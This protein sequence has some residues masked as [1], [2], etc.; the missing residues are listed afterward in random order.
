MNWLPHILEN[1]KE[2]FGDSVEIGEEFK[3]EW[4][5]IPHIYNVPFYVYAYSFGQLLVLSLYKQ[6]KAEGE[7]FKPRYIKILS[8]GG[9]EAPEKVLT[10]AGIDFRQRSFWQGGFDVI[11][12]LVTQLEGLQIPS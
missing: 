9:S 2:Q 7:S 1:L 12:D 6:F 8:A 10:D 11:K 4:V 5:S 3:W